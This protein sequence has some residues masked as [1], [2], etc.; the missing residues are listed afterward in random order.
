MAKKTLS[1]FFMLILIVGT[2]NCS[3]NSNS[4]Q[5]VPTIDASATLIS[6]DPAISITTSP[7]SA[8]ENLRYFLQTNGNCK[9]P[10]FWGIQPDHTSY[11]ELYGLFQQLGESGSDTSV[12]NHLYVSSVFRFEERG[13]L[14]VDFQADVQEDVVKNMVTT[15]DGLWRDD[16][17]PQDWSAY[18][19]SEILSTY[20]S[21]DSV[22][23][24][25]DIPNNTLAFGIRLRY[26][27]L[28]TSILYSGRSLID[29][30]N[31]DAS[32]AIIC[33]V[34]NISSIKLHIGEQPFN[35][36]PNGVELSDA[37]NLDTQ[38]FYEL[39]TE[40]PSACL[41]VNLAAMGLR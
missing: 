11:D 16:V 17:F 22:E 38:A 39:F 5:H 37:T 23:I 2:N 24:F 34:E 26:E 27:D 12:D 6:T 25:L 3:R 28:N 35:Y 19:I 10:C 36:E 30:N 18:A 14:Y 1:L 8:R 32:N 15:F 4:I 40:N 9:F 31:L 13:G 41:T 21:P 7:D 20:G 29:A 33:P